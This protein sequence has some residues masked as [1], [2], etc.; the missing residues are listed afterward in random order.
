M[1]GEK[2]DD[3][4]LIYQALAVYANIPERRLVNC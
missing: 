1:L 4:M 2:H 3:R